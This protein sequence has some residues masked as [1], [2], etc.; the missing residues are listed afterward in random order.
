MAGILINEPPVLI[1]AENLKNREMENIHLYRSLHEKH[2]MVRV[3]RHSLEKV[4]LS[5]VLFFTSVGVSVQG[6]RVNP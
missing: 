5:L 1:T 3:Y 4:K 2:G 6:G